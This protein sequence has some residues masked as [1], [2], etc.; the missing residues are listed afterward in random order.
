MHR[1][2]SLG[3]VFRNNLYMTRDAVPQRV[4]KHTLSSAFYYTVYIHVPTLLK[5]P[6]L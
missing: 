1:A 4:V 5:Y 2:L 6:H 3:C